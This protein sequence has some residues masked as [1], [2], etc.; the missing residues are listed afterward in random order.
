MVEEACG[1]HRRQLTEPRGVERCD[2][3]GRSRRAGKQGSI[4]WNSGRMELSSCQGDGRSS[5]RGREE[6]GS[7][8]TAFQGR[9]ADPI[10]EVDEGVYAR[11]GEPA[12][13]SRCDGRSRGA[14]HQEDEAV[15]FDLERSQGTIGKRARGGAKGVRAMERGL[16]VVE[17]RGERNVG[18]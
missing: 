1:I 2:P 13:E 4:V 15:V 3:K 14:V 18:P 10:G 16:D 5:G 12:G 8:S 6:S 11:D 9:V 17:P 7:D